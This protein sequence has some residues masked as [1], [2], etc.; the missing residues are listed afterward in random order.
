VYGCADMVGNVVEWT[1]TIWGSER[2]APDFR[3]PYVAD[4]GREESRASSP[5][6]ELRV[7][8]GGSFRDPAERVT[9]FARS[10]QAADSGAA[11][12]GFRVACAE[13]EG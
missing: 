1:S 10:R 11:N 5:F 3:P 8:R 13:T 12:R 9:C 7:C 6:R 4:D 2:S